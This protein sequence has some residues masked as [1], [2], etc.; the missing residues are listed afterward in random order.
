MNECINNN[1]SMEITSQEGEMPGLAPL[2]SQFPQ[3]I[4]LP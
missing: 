1:F 3:G 4:F 2:T